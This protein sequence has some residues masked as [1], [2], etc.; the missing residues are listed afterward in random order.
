M[1]RRKPCRICRKWFS[2]SP[3]AGE[4]QKV[5]SDPA[6]QRERHRRSC[7]A[8]RRRKPTGDMERRFRKKLR[9]KDE[10][11][12]SDV[13][14]QREVVASG[15]RDAAIAKSTVVLEE[16]GRLIE[17]AARDAA[18]ATLELRGAKPRRLP[19][20]DARDA[21]SRSPPAS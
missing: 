10:W 9:A 8:G 11:K 21:A 17:I 16:H 6:C 1:A 20:P 7:E 15:A 2:P 5:C 18:I 19:P 3:F 14:V 4:R 13:E 12:P